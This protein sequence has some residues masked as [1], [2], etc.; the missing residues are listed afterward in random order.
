ML[1]DISSK[2]EL[3]EVN[4]KQEQL[5]SEMQGQYQLAMTLFAREA[6]AI[7]KLVSILIHQLNQPITAIAAY[8]YSGLHLISNQSET[9]CTGLAE[10][11]NKIAEQTKQ[12]G[13][14]TSYMHDV[15]QNDDFV[16]EN[17]D[18][19]RLIEETI[20]IL[21]SDLEDTGFKLIL[22]LDANLSQIMASKM[23]VMGVMLRLMR[24]LLYQS[25]LDSEL[26]IETLE[27]NGHIVI[28]FTQTHQANTDL[29]KTDTNP[30]LCHLLIG[31]VGGVLRAYEE[32]ENRFGFTLI[33]PI[34]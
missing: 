34:S 7:K 20:A 31:A 16:I 11:F 24:N 33:L 3:I 14:M 12:L 23:I 1:S 10:L 25:K 2:N 5:C 22:N 21:K 6:A 26:F 8:S 13:M 15:L 4:K 27:A 18:I 19:N 17:T 32:Q 30:N 28:H 29:M 9:P